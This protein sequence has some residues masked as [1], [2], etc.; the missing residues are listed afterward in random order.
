MKFFTPW[1]DVKKPIENW[2][3]VKKPIETLV[4]FLRDITYAR[5][6]QFEK[7]KLRA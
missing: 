5:R 1:T 3:D 6:A 2:T 4:T 7:R